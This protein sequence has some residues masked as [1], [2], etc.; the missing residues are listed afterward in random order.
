V[1]FGN[2]VKEASV[3]HGTTSAFGLWH[4][5]A[6]GCVALILL[7]SQFPKN[8]YRG[9]PLSFSLDD[10]ALKIAREVVENGFYE[11]LPPP[12]RLF[13]ILCFVNSEDVA[14]VEEG[15]TMMDELLKKLNPDQFSR[16]TG[17]RKTIGQH[18]GIVQQYGRYPQR[19]KALSRLSTSEELEFLSNP[20][21]W[22]RF[23]HKT[24]QAEKKLKI[25]TENKGFK[26]ASIVKA[27]GIPVSEYGFAKP[28]VANGKVLVLH[29]FRSSDKVQ[30]CSFFFQKNIDPQQQS[31]KIDVD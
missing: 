10:A 9:N 26:A 30:L 5:T 6:Q 28:R 2:A 25:S 31:L 15:V 19:N 23:V 4:E 14:V 16:M 17:Y 8:I 20:S 29:H 7:M 1:K 18:L 12:Q 11:E 22:P 3:N 21:K 13:V 27:A 24:V